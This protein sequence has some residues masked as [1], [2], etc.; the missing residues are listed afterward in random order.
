MGV[1]VTTAF[2]YTSP[3]QLETIASADNS[4]INSGKCA[5]ATMGTFQC[6]RLALFHPNVHKWC[7]RFL[8]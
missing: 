1:C 5:V 7:S 2:T 4:Y 8:S 6:T 3:A